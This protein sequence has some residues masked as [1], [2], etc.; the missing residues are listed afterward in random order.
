MTVRIATITPTIRSSSSVKPALDGA[1]G[2]EMVF[3]RVRSC[4]TASLFGHYRGELHLMRAEIIAPRNGDGHIFR[5][6][7]RAA[8]HG[9]AACER[10]STARAACL[11]QRFVGCR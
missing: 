2:E 1:H 6:G 11:V 8:H 7:Q 10:R 5:V 9:P 3:I 4:M